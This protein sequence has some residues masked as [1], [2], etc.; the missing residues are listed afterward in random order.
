MSN[1]TVV[2]KLTI[3]EGMTVL[4]IDAPEG[5]LA[6]LGTLPAN[7][8]IATERSPEVDVVLAFVRSKVALDAL[9]AQFAPSLA[10]GVSLW[11][12]FQKGT[13]KPKPD[14]NRDDVLACAEAAGLR[15]M[16]LIAVDGSWSA[17]R[18]VAKT[19]R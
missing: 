18:F 6:A 12:A 16:T 17:F 8:T 11:I 19:P 9:V 1:K 10:A 2:E 4:C 14:F 13:V 7:V 3:R 15:S 5:Y